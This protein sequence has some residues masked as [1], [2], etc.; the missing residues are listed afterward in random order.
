MTLPALLLAAATLAGALPGLRPGSGP[1]PG[2]GSEL[3]GDAGPVPLPGCP[4]ANPE[5]F[6]ALPSYPPCFEATLTAN[7]TGRPPLSFTWSLPGGQ[8]LQGNPVVLDTGLLPTGFNEV[9]LRV[10]NDAGEAL[11]PV[12]VVVEDLAFEAAPDLVVTGGTTVATSANT[13]GATEWRWSWGDGTVTPWTAGCAGY[14]PSHT[15]AAPG[16]YTVTVE[17]RSCRG[18]PIAMSGTLVLGSGPALGIERFAVVCPTAPFCRFAAGEVV[19][20]EVSVAGGP[21]AYLYDWNG[22]GI[23]DEVASGVVSS[24]VYPSAGYFTPRLTVLAGSVLDQAAL[25]VPV[26]IVAGTGLL[27]SEDFEGGDLGDWRLP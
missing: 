16:E 21:E 12:S 9:V 15:Y 20:F 2:P 4:L 17:A 19:P 8:V 22:D 18:G 27:F 24:H 1:E 3:R 14:Q 13:R 23:D 5:A 11:Y 7:A 6:G 26:E 10:A 25:E